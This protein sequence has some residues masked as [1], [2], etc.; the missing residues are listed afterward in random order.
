MERAD[1][2]S[3]VTAITVTYN[4][5]KTLVRCIEALISQTRI[6]DDIVIVDNHSAEEEQKIIR[7]YVQKYESI[8][9]SQGSHF[10]IIWLDSNLGGAGGF[11][12]GMRY[13]LQDL[14]P[15]FYWIMDDDAYPEKNCLDI[16]LS[17]MEALPNAGCVCPLIYGI[18]LKQYQ[19]FHHKHLSR[20][21]LHTRPASR[22]PEALKEPIRLDANAFVGPLFSKEAVETSGVADGSLFIYGDDTEYTYRV[23]QKYGVYLIPQAVIEHQD[24]PVLDSNMSAKGWWKEYYGNRNQ[25][26]LIREAHQ[27]LIVRF[28]AY[29]ALT[30]RILAVILKSRLKGYHHFRDRMLL[31][32]V[33]DGLRNKRGKRVDPVEYMRYLK[34]RGIQ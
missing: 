6:V 5:T 7:E 32:A 20:L 30:G 13:A 12:A 22:H 27:N 25:F 29:T 26:F 3:R 9:E 14:H 28:I 16:L 8:N 31:K 23:S 21:I 10:H 18:D 15:D 34:E 4:R 2:Y 33:S 17:N 24:A 11:E 19:F 1:K